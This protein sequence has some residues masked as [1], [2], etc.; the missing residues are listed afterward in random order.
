MMAVQRLPTQQLAAGLLDQ[1]PGRLLVV[2]AGSLTRGAPGLVGDFVCA[3]LGA[4]LPRKFAFTRLQGFT[5]RVLC[6]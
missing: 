1:M 2:V 5:L 4:C 3:R 6:N